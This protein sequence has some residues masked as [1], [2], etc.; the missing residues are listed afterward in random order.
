MTAAG[1]G[2]AY[3]NAVGHICGERAAE[4]FLADL[5]TSCPTGDELFRF[6]QF[7]GSFS[8]DVDIAFMCGF[9]RRI[10][11]HLE[12][13]PATQETKLAQPRSHCSINSCVKG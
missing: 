2:V 7:F 12:R 10:Q 3:S 8:S 5:A 13:A 4:K 9:C 6:V 11:K 1:A